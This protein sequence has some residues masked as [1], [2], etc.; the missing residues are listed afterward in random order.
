M[1]RGH[2]IYRHVIWHI[3]AMVFTGMLYGTYMCMC[4]HMCMHMHML[5][6]TCVLYGTCMCLPEERF[7]CDCAPLS[8][9]HRLPHRLQ[10]MHAWHVH[11]ICIV[12]A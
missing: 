10:F 3:H 12:R 9:P 7:R 2:G 11:S 5:Y 6:G 4:M 1:L 8:G